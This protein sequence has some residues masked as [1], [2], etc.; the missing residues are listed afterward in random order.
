[1]TLK[2]VVTYPN[3]EY[4]TASTQERCIICG[5]SGYVELAVWKEID[6]GVELEGPARSGT[7]ATDP[8]EATGDDPL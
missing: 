1:V 4:C 5:G 8:R 3:C 6:D 2:R 7:S